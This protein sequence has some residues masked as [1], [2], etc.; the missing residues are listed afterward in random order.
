[1][2][3]SWLPLDTGR[4]D[5][6]HESSRWG[7]FIGLET[8]SLYGDCFPGDFFLKFSSSLET[9]QDFFSDRLFILLNGKLVL[10]PALDY[11][12]QFIS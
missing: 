9:C 2:L 8:C 3:K 11:A 1:M 6:N 7:L 12:K 10:K 5:P 4:T